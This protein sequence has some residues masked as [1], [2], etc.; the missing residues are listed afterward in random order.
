MPLQKDKDKELTDEEFLEACRVA[1]LD[2]NLKS[3][4][5]R[6]ADKRVSEGIKSFEK[7]QDKNGLSDKEEIQLLKNKLK[8]IE[9]TMA[10]RD[11]DT[12]I[13]AELKTQNL[14]EGLIKYIV[15]DDPKDVGQAVKELKDE[16]LSLQQ[17]DIDKKLEGSSR[18]SQGDKTSG[19]SALESYIE[20]K[21]KGQGVSSPFKGKLES[22]EV[23]K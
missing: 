6:I 2:K 4:T 15:V 19:N 23:T 13:K 16:I 10:K 14:S 8:D 20:S 3:Y 9:G 11:I 5:S 21:N 17:E 18:P 22:N 7:H 12:L 1:G